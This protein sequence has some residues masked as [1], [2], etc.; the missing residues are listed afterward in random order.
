MA[1]SRTTL[2]QNRST[3]AA[4]AYATASFTPAANALITAAIR[5]YSS[6]DGSGTVTLT[7][8]GLTWVE[9]DHVDFENL[10]PNLAR[11]TLFRAMGASPTNGALTIN[12]SG[13]TNARC[14][15]DVQQFGGVPTSGTNGSGAIAQSATNTG[16]TNGI[17][18]TLAALGDAA[19]NAVYLA[20]GEGNA[21]MTITAGAG[22]TK[23][24]D[25]QD[26][27]A[28]EAMATEWGLPGTTTPGITS[29]TNAAN[30]AIAIEIKAADT[31]V[32]PIGQAMM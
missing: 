21:P 2:T 8:N 11:V 32:P 13:S 25:L 15:W 9:I 19:N 26:T 28:A 29:S 17:T 24:A 23:L 30:G 4:Q 20:Y 6:S 27:G 16:G 12:I 3:S 1:I 5:T 18:V 7:G 31:T 10:P 22:Y 14:M